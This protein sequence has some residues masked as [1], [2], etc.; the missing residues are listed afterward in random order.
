MKIVLKKTPQNPIIIEGFPG[1]GLVGTI[2][3]EFL[4]DHLKAEMIGEFHYQELAPIAAV[5]KGA[6]V[7]PMAIWYV[8]Q[9]NIVLLHTI[10]NVKGFEW[11]IANAISEMAKKMKAKQ[12][13]G[14]EGVATDDLSGEAKAYYYG[15]KK[16]EACGAS[17]VKESIIM[18]VSSALMLRNPKTSCIFASTHS[19]LPDSKAAAKLIEILDKYLDLNVDYKPLLKQAEEF[20][21]KLKTIMQQSQKTVREADKKTMSYLG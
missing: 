3:T 7:N 14:L 18:G 6:L 9:R 17:P 1:F 5:H 19:Q 15:D 2:T 20:E 11:E 16:L 8:P 4:L 10:L 12:I 13:I 21:N